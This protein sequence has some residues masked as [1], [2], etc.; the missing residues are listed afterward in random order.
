MKC[1]RWMLPA[2]RWALQPLAVL[3]FAHS[4]SAQIASGGDT[5]LFRSDAA[6][7]RIEPQYQAQPLMVGPLAAEV[8]FTARMLF[9]SNIYRT[10]KGGTNDV[11]FEAVPSLRLLGDFGPHSATISARARIK[12][13][14]RFTSENS[15]TIDLSA[16]G[17]MELGSQSSAT[18]LTRY[19]HET[20]SRGSAGSNLIT[21]GPSDLQIL[22]SAWTAR[23]DYGR[24]NVSVAAGVT[25]RSFMAL[26]L[27][28]GRTL[29]Q[30]F[31]DTRALT[32]APRASFGIGSSA[33]VFVAGSATKTTSVNRQV[34]PLRDASSHTLLAGVR[35]ET[36]GLVIAEIGVGWRGQNYSNPLFEDFN[37][38]TYDATIDWYPTR[39]FSVRV[40]AGQD[41]ANSGIANVAGILRRTLALSAYYDPLRN[42]RFS[43][44]ADHEH[45]E[46]RELK[47][48]SDTVSASLTGRYQFDRNLG[49]SAFARIQSKKSSNTASIDGFTGVAVGAV[50]TA[51]L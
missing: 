21:A 25:Q 1:V 50:L 22:Q 47:Q 41:I 28:N 27:Q 8:A 11:S 33:A 10:S 32:V 16:G 14:A 12:R 51:T 43:F 48:S 38:L 49:A 20:E 4:A 29:D 3:G 31:R 24:L 6:G 7:V 44:S 13:F 30:S 39:L 42:L 40:Q 5:I 9:D 19:A 23:S 34:R 37:G 17:R 26:S 35:T 18:W 15:D 36:N 2:G 45:D 46:F